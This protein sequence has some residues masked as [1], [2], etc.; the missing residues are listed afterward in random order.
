M[1]SKKRVT[2]SAECKE[3]DGFKTRHNFLYAA[4]C[5]AFFNGNLRTK[6]DVLRCCEDD[7]DFIDFCLREAIITKGK[8]DE[9]KKREKEYQ[10]EFKKIGLLESD[11]MWDTPFFI[12]SARRKTRPGVPIIRVGCSNRIANFKFHVEHLQQM[13]DFIRLLHRADEHLFNNSL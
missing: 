3:Y 9:L 5:I 7:R 2:F 13:C 12:E 6:E 11:P 10:M 8:L 4:I 1:S